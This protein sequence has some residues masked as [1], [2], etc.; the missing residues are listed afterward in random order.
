VSKKAMFG[1]TSNGISLIDAVTFEDLG[2]MV[3]LVG[4][5]YQ[6]ELAEKKAQDMGYTVIE[7]EDASVFEWAEYHFNKHSRTYFDKWSYESVSEID[8]LFSKHA[9]WGVDDAYYAMS[10]AISAFDGPDG[11]GRKEVSWTLFETLDGGLH[12][13]SFNS[14]RRVINATTDMS[15]L[16]ARS[17]MAR[18]IS[19][20]STDGISSNIEFPHQKYAMFSPDQYRLGR[21]QI[22]ADGTLSSTGVEKASDFNIYFQRMGEAA[23]RVFEPKAWV[24]ERIRTWR[25]IKGITQGDLAKRIGSA[26]P[27]ISAYE[28]GKKEMGIT[29]LVKILHALRIEPNDILGG[30]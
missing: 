12:W 5:I 2:I 18:L 22:V 16:E 28:G 14:A 13:F 15:E 19:L 23:C 3:V 1:H 24:G 25:S 20:H 6:P 10:E 29:Q 9:P 17:L 7:N 21:W 30:L 11:K 4:E 27:V 26:A 8:P